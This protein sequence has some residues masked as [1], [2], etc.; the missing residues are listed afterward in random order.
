MVVAAVVVVEM[1]VAAV[2]VVVDVVAVVFDVVGLKTDEVEAAGPWK[3][4][5]GSVT[6]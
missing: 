1:V 5:F 2:V 4:G 3:N 6:A